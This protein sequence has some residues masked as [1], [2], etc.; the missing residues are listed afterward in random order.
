MFTCQDAKW[1]SRDSNPTSLASESTLLPGMFHWD[2]PEGRTAVQAVL[3]AGAA[4]E[5][6]AL[7]GHGET[8]AESSSKRDQGLHLRTSP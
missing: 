4:V 7:G 2:L 6:T 3:K 1:Q 8:P 5:E